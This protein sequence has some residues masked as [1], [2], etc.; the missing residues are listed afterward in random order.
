MWG[1]VEIE[2][3]KT[4]DNTVG[5]KQCEKIRRRSYDPLAVSVVKSST[6]FY[7]DHI[8]TVNKRNET[9]REYGFDHAMTVKN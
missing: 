1:S 2:T 7:F 6:E 8:K 9:K 4:C 3:L 5:S